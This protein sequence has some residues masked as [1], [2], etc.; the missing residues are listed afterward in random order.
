MWRIILWAV[1]AIALISIV[2]SCLQNYKADERIIAIFARPSNGRTG[3]KAF[4][5]KN[6]KGFREGNLFYANIKPLRQNRLLKKVPM[7]VK[8]F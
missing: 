3:G 5:G 8:K 1:V 2:L 4:K 6:K 7:L